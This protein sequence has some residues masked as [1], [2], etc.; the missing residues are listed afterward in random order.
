MFR[1][2]IDLSVNRG[3]AIETPKSVEIRLRRF[4]KMYK[5]TLYLL[6]CFSLNQTSGPVRTNGVNQYVRKTD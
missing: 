4:P 6:R 1:Y 2:F 5:F 3:K